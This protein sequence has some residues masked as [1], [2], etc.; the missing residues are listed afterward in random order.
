M[1]RIL[2]TG[3]AG[4]IGYSISTFL[5][6]KKYEVIGLDNLSNYYDI[7]I[8]N[9]RTAELLKYKNFKFFKINL[10]NK[11]KLKKLFEKEKF[12]IVLN[13]AAQAGV[14]YSFIN[15]DEYIKTNINGFFNLIELSKEKKIKHFV[16]A[17]SSSVYGLSNK[18]QSSEEDSVDHPISLYA[19]TKR[20]NELIAHSYSYN[21]NL[22]TTGIRF[23]TVYGEFGRP[24]MSIFKFIKKNLQ[25]KHIQ[26]FNHGKHQRSFSNIHDVCN[27]LFEII[28]SKKKLNK[29]NNL[30]KLNPGISI[31]PFEIYN[32]GNPSKISLINL[33]KII[34]SKLGRK[35]K[36]K[37]LGLQKG[38]I[39]S[40]HASEKKLI[41]NFKNNFKI[42]IS[43]GI[44]KHIDWFLKN[45]KFLLKLKD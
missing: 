20:S 45:K 33:I 23:F 39:V 4:F 25:N 9:K 35:T 11:N 28:K 21:F 44:Q 24:D 32:I 10:N 17:S 19:A 5:L 22:R 43:T 2:V 13:L 27:F 14:R 42:D 16:Y 40:T 29:K 6:K 30:K 3:S 7:R 15:P 12:D 8:K 38:D 1:P 41:K 34:E 18:N 31:S 36:K 37:Y 26:V